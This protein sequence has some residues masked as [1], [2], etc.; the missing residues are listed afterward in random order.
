M[1]SRYVVLQRMQRKNN[2]KRKNATR[3][4]QWK[5]INRR[6]LKR[7]KRIEESVET[8]R[9]KCKKRRRRDKT[10]KNRIRSLAVLKETNRDAERDEQET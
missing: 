9:R 2:E 3:D 4:E 1:K 5:K 8:E 10:N 7:E 6:V